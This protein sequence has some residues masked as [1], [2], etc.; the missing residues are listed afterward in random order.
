MEQQ[1]LLH[2][3]AYAPWT[4]EEDEKLKEYF[5]GGLR[6]SKIAEKMD[7]N[8]GSISSRIKKLGLQTASQNV[9]SVDNSPE[10]K[11]TILKEYEEE[12]RK[13][14]AMKAEIEEKIKGLVSE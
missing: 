7:R 8:N 5:F 14:E 10:S 11:E 4:E 2:A 12:L 6:V 1:K 3:K 9:P 13:L